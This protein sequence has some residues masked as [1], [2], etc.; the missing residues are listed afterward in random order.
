MAGFNN[1]S[2]EVLA[3][4]IEAHSGRFKTLC[5]MRNAK[6]PEYSAAVRCLAVALCDK[7]HSFKNKYE[8]AKCVSQHFYNGRKID[9]IDAYY[10]VQ[11]EFLHPC[12]TRYEEEEKK[13]D[14]A[15][16]EVEEVRKRI[17]RCEE[18]RKEVEEM[19]T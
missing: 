8:I 5:E 6:D 10:A 7:S 11:Q 2:S 15:R 1:V 16:K 4:M 13:R 9:F 14:E 18:S 17:A 12:I 19:K 3:E